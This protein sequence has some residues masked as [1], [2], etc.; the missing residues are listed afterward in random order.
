MNLE[1]VPRCRNGDADFTF[2]H[3]DRLGKDA[4]LNIGAENID[5]DLV[6]G[7]AMARGAK[8]AEAHDN[9]LRGV[10]LGSI[11]RHHVQ[12]ATGHGNARE[13][14]QKCSGPCRGYILEVQ[15]LKHVSRG[16]IRSLD[17]VDETEARTAGHLMGKLRHDGET[18]A[19]LLLFR[20]PGIFHVRLVCR[21]HVFIAVDASHHR[22]NLT[23]LVSKETF[24]IFTHDLLFL[25]LMSY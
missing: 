6:V 19:L 9:L 11:G 14:S 17:S 24:C 16:K 25:G 1:A 22:P 12:K 20:R 4:L 23:N 2:L 8:V 10:E 15:L 21:V 18:A 3:R 13:V 7:R 5:V